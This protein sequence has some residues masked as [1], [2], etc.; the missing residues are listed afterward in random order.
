[1]DEFV[2][3]VRIMRSARLP[4]NFYQ[5]M[6]EENAKIRI[7]LIRNYRK[8]SFAGRFSTHCTRKSPLAVIRPR[9]A[10]RMLLLRANLKETT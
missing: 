1:M 9:I 8:L 4:S 5:M 7:S 2:V 6:K 3:G 10:V